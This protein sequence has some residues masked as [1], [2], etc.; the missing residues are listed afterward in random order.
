MI[1]KVIEYSTNTGIYNMEYDLSLLSNCKKDTAFLRFYGW[2]PECI[3]LGANQ[4]FDDIDLLLAKN[5]NID[6][7]KRPTGGRAILHADELTYSVV[8]FSEG[9][10]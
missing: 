6:V 3:S 8:M 10:S 9:I 7:V 4:S 2:Q 5:N 1:W